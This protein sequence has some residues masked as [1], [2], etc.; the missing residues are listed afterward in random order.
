MTL[1]YNFQ[2]WLA[3]QCNIGYG[4]KPSY[5]DMIQISD[6]HAVTRGRLGCEQRHERQHDLSCS[7]A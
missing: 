2:I 6:V 4:K 3:H 5:Y 1:A 7:T